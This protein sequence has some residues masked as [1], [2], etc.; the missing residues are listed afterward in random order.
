QLRNFAWEIADSGSV[1]S[2]FKAWEQRLSSSEGAIAA[3]ALLWLTSLPLQHAS[4]IMS[5]E[6]S[7]ITLSSLYQIM[8]GAITYGTKGRGG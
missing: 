8:T 1:K 6:A 2:V 4:F 3:C 5:E 7:L